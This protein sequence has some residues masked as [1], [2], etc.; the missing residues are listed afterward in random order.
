[1]HMLFRVQTMTFYQFQFFV[2]VD[3]VFPLIK[4]T[5]KPIHNLFI[6]LLNQ[7]EEMLLKEILIKYSC[8]Q[9]TSI[10]MTDILIQEN[11][12]QLST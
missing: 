5:S 7:V 6:C 3:A 4:K 1:M 12:D 11:G 9:I 2:V 8:E 10:N